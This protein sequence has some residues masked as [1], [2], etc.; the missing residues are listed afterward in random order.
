MLFFKPVLEQDHLVAF[1]FVLTLYI[2]FIDNVVVSFAES[3]NAVCMDPEHG[4]MGQFS[5]YSIRNLD[6]NLRFTALILA[7]N[8]LRFKVDRHT[9]HHQDRKVPL[10]RG[11]PRLG[12]FGL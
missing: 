2:A 12:V 11:I 6:S 1:F 7:A 3:F 8:L 5:V 10:A 4:Y 9:R